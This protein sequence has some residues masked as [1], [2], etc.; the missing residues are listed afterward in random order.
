[1]A[2]EDNK[3]AAK[4]EKFS[5][6]TFSLHAGQSEKLDNLVDNYF[7]RTGKRITRDDIIR[8]LIDQCNLFMLMDRLEK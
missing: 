8:M 7:G 3:P 5:Q 2:L 6:A 1:M 4:Q